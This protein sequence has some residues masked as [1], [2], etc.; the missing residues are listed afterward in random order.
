LVLYLIMVTFSGVTTG[1]ASL[2]VGV[3]VVVLVAVV[4]LPPLPLPLLVVVVV[5]VAAMSAENFV[6]SK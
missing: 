6:A 4:L 5:D 3:D 1:L 2:V